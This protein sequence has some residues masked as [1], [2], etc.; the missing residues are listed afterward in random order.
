MNVTI[1]LGEPF[2]RAAGQRAVAVELCDGARVAEAL[3]ALVRRY[4]ALRGALWDREALPFVFV[5]DAEAGPATVLAPE[6]E[7]HV[8]WPASGG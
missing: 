1:R 7:V 5:G 3:E 8:V 6:S 2:W 4:P